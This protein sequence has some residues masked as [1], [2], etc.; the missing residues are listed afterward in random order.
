MIGGVKEKWKGEE[1][2]TD[3]EWKEDSRER[4]REKD[5]YNKRG[6]G[7]NAPDIEREGK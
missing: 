2:E 4:E 5:R 7:G 6:R 3:E 1:M